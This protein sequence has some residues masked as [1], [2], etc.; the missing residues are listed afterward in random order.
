MSR[1]QQIRGWKYLIWRLEKSPNKQ[2]L[3]V[4]R[5]EV[6]RSENEEDTKRLVLGGSC[7]QSPTI[8]A[9]SSV[10]Y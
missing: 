3:G 5:S 6:L 8:V 4:F 1:R 7:I 9:E 2:P 10:L